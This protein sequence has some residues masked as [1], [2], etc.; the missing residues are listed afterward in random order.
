MPGE[1]DVLAEVRHWTGGHG[2]D[3][4]IIT[5]ASPSDAIVQQAMEITRQKGRVVVVGDVGL[6]LK[7]SPFYEKEIDFLISCSYGPGRYD[8]RYERQGLDYPYA[9]V[10]W[11]EKRNMEEYLRL[12]AEGQVTLD[13]ILERE[14]DLADAPA[15][16]EEL[17]TAQDKPLGVLLAY[18]LGDER[19]EQ[20]LTT[21][22]TLKPFKPSGKVQVAVIGAGSFAKGVHLPNLQKLSELYHLRAIVSATGSNARA[23]A[24]QFGAEYATT[25]YQDVLDDSS[26]DMVLICTRHHLH[27]PMAIRAAQAGKA[28]FLEK[29][30]ALNQKELDQLLSVLG[31]TG[32]PFTVGFNRRF[33]PAARRMKEIVAKRHN[34]LMVLYRVNAGHVPVDHWAHGPEGGGRITG[35]ACH[36]FDLFNHLVDAQVEAVVAEP[37]STQTEGVSS[38]DNVS[39]T[40]R[41]VDGSV[42]TLFY[43]SL[44]EPGVGKEYLEVYVDGKVLVADD[45]QSL[46]LYGLSGKGWRASGP[47]KGHRQMLECF[48]RS[49]AGA[50]PWPI[51][52]EQLV[53]ATRVSF[54]VS[55][56]SSTHVSE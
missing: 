11:T 18:G 9:Y 19:R 52:M 14:Y 30:M 51:A 5:A 28:V 10:R 3:A 20:K 22:V 34:P 35:E 37:L 6:G 33:S 4:T 44:G 42:C 8:Q 45:F 48:A 15:A 43:T 53:S 26:V 25:D 2:V 49:L 23:T 12:V 1:V 16:Y 40:V 38:S 54:F 21:R 55:G 27:A 56:A 32:V 13:S 39:A 31:D 36:M 24:E 47:D 17:R 7:R 50:N 29:P 46:Q 41:Y